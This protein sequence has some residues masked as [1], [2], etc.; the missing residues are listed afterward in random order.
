MSTTLL[1]KSLKILLY[2]IVK[3][4]LN[5]YIIRMTWVP[6][7]KGFKKWKKDYIINGDTNNILSTMDDNSIDLMITSPSYFLWKDYEWNETFEEYLEY[8][9]KT[10]EILFKK[11]KSNWSVYRNV[12]QTPINGEIIPLWAI[13]YQYFKDAWF[14]L[15]NR[16]IRHFEWGVNT[17]NRLSGRYENILRFVKNKD[18]FTFNL[19]E[20][21]V[22]SKWSND[23]RNNPKWKNPTDVREFYKDDLDKDEIEY[24]IKEIEKDRN[25]ENADHTD[26][27]MYINRV[28]NIS[29]EKTEHP[30]Q[31]PEK[32]IERIIKA[33]SN[34]WDMVV[35]IF[36][37]S[38]TVG[39]KAV[40][41]DRKFIWI[42][43]SIEY[44]KIS[45]D[46]IENFIKNNK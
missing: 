22:P 26:N 1:L 39:K 25:R 31:F 42:D 3:D 24:F 34:K 41:L 16:I 8:H 12:A 36:L 9:K 29:K 30:C 7:V 21:R 32:L 11:I 18:N 2:S 19:D 40:E 10:I 45:K 37:W 27:F 35:D 20:I 5:N 28:V 46:R 33:S 15:K 44:C 43:R 13:F 6:I 4:Y 23:K 14:Y 38:G 17:K